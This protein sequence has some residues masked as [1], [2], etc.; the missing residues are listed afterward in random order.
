MPEFFLNTPPTQADIARAV[1]YGYAKPGEHKPHPFNALDDFARGYVESMFFTNGDTGD[2]RE[3]LLNDLGAG[4]LTR[5]AVAK[6]AADCAAF[7]AAAAPLLALAYEP[8]FC[9]DDTQAGRDFW[10]TR[11]GHGCGFWSRTDETGLG[12]DVGRMPDGELMTGT[13]AEEAGAAFEG[14]L[15]ELLSNAARGMGE[16][17]VETHRGWIHV[18]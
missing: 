1:A 17:Y 6:I 7:Q 3:N 4:R 10:F 18:C 5:A 9:Y 13:E 2:E 12:R 14:S 11:Q 16:S 15:G 8:P